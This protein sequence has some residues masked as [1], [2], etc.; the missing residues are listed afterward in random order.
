MTGHMQGATTV[1]FVML[2]VIKDI[3]KRLNITIMYT[4]FYSEKH[5]TFFH[6]KYV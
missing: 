6:I 1:I 4:M 3:F 5:L 2:I